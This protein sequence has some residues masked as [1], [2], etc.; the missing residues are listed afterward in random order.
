MADCGGEDR[1]KQT[2]QGEVCPDCKI[3]VKDSDDAVCCGLC[4]FWHHIKCEGVSREV[5]TF[6]S[7]GDA[8]KLHW[9]CNK[10]DIVAG[11]MLSPIT[12]L[13][14]GQYKIENEMDKFVKETNTKFQVVENEIEIEE[15]NK[16]LEVGIVNK[17]EKVQQEI[18]NIKSKLVEEVKEK[19]Y[20]EVKDNLMKSCRDAVSQE[21]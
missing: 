11:K 5:Y 18:T 15:A 19:V 17:C 20:T 16:I 2:E 12:K 8:S 14:K 7:R 1:C 4:D 13:E 21:D 10:C 6:P 9:F 3:R